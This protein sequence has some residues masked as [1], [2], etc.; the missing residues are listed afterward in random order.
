MLCHMDHSN[1]NA[2]SSDMPYGRIG[3]AWSRSFS[4]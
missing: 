4:P 1:M 3:L 2:L